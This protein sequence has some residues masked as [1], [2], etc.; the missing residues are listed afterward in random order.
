MPSSRYQVGLWLASPYFCKMAKIINEKAGFK[1]IQV[2][3]EELIEKLGHL[4]SK[5][6]NAD[7]DNIVET[8]GM[9]YLDEMKRDYQHDCNWLLRLKSSLGPESQNLVNMVNAS[10]QVVIRNIG[11]LE[12]RIAKENT[13]S[14]GA[15]Q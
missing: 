10:I 11:L 5:G 2:S 13:N 9:G 3:R 7:E 8:L 1:T 12:E 15:A 6:F 14:P 4:G